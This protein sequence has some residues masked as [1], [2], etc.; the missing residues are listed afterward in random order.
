MT[1]YGF[2]PPQPTLPFSDLPPMGEKLSTETTAQKAAADQNDTTIETILGHKD[3][4]LLF[5]TMAVSMTSKN[6]MPIVRAYTGDIPSDF[7][8]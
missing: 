2:Y 3:P 7:K 6:E 5:M 1:Q 4:T 8:V